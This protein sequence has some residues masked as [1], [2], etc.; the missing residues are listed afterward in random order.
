VT[1]TADLLDRIDALATRALDNWRIP[2]LAF[3]LVRPGQSPEIRTYGCRDNASPKRVTA[4]TQF[5]TCSL[6]KSF[7]AAGLLLLLAERQLPL[8]TRVRDLLPEFRLSDAVIT[9]QITLRDLLCHASGLPRHDRIWTPGD[10]TRAEMLARL[11]HLAFSSGLRESYQYNNLGY[12]VLAA[13]TERL[14]GRDWESYTTDTLLRP[15]GFSQFGWTPEE[16]E[17]ADDHAHPHPRDG[18]GITRGK[19]WPAPVPA[20]GLNASIGD[21]ARWLQ[22]LLGEELPGVAAERSRKVLADMM[23]PWMYSGTSPHAEIGAS[24]Y[25]LGLASERYRNHRMVGH[26]GSMPGW[27]SQML[28]LPDQQVGVVVLTNRDPTPIPHMLAFAVFDAVCG[29]ESID[30]YTRF[31]DARTKFLAEEAEERAREAAAAPAQPARGLSEYVGRYADA[32]YGEIEVTQ[33]DGA[34]AWAC[35]GL[36]GAMKPR[37]HDRFTLQETPPARHL[38]AWQGTFLCDAKGA[39]DRLAIPLEPS[40]PEIVFRRG[41]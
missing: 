39:V 13:V 7:T 33:Q 16:L 40:V 38:D 26:G 2:G 1:S 6:T 8:T 41:A 34:L 5:H 18:A 36:G 21:M 3:A 23:T 29:L 28:L 14:S 17:S 32:A 27:S 31:A 24:H 37:G 12:L 11:R 22:F 35:R 4:Q 19:V 9:E 20:G 30:W 10:L 25:G 15:L